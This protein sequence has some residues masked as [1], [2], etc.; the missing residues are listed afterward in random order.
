MKKGDVYLVEIPFL[1]GHEQEGTRPAI[2]LSDTKTPIAIVVPCTSNTHALRF[3]FTLRIENSKSNGFKEL[4]IALVFHL[5]SI[6][7]SRFKKRIGSLE[8][9][10]I[11][12]LDKM[13]RNL[14][15]I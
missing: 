10:H 8:T 15:T 9:K 14:L 12:Q 3:P 11:R 2:I 13:I 6:D 7:K 5:R 4:T 1:G